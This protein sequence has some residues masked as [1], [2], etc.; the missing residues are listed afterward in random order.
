MAI[1]RCFP[2]GYFTYTRISTCSLEDY[3]PG[4][5]MRILDLDEHRICLI[6][7]KI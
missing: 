2:R 6:V 1:I 5:R 4:R 3:S 7:R